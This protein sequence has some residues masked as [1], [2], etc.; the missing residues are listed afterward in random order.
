MTLIEHAESEMR[1][2]G[3]YESHA[4]YDGHLADA[5]MALVKLFAEQ[6][7]SGASASLALNIFDKLARFENLTPLTTDP[8][9]WNQVG[10]DAWQNRR[11]PA[12]FSNDGGQTAYDSHTRRPYRLVAG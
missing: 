1:R 11:N 12:V 3:L 5:V 7:H 9:E 2:A 4:D 6:G 10:S 8:A